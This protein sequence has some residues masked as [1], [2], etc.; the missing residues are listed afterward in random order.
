MKIP[1]IFLCE[2]FI[3]IFALNKEN[4]PI[5][6]T[7]DVFSCRRLKE[8]RGREAGE[9]Q[10]W[11]T[12]VFPVCKVSSSCFWSFQIKTDFG[13]YWQNNKPQHDL[14]FHRVMSG[15]TS[16]KRTSCRRKITADI[17]QRFGN[18]WAS[19]TN[20]EQFCV[21]LIHSAQRLEESIQTWFAATAIWA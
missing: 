17:Q 2:C 13:N 4:E 21:K 3:Y 16:Y 9:S 14:R 6:C 1:F 20:R 15:K 11:W 7:R 18:L 5:K 19:Q 8:Q 10:A 12:H